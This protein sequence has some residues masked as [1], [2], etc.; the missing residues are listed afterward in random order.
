[1]PGTE[2][3]YLMVPLPVWSG[4]AWRMNCASPFHLPL[5]SSSRHSAICLRLDAQQGLGEELEV[6]VALCP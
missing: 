2:L 6:L 5:P 4:A 3:H 1:M